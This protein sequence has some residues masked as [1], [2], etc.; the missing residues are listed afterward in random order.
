LVA[1]TVTSYAAAAARFVAEYTVDGQVGTLTAADVVRAV[2]DEC[3]RVS[4]GTAQYFVTALRSFLRFCRMQGLIDAEL[5]IAA[6]PVTGH[7]PSQLPK[8]ISSAEAAALLRS[9]DRRRAIGRRNYAVLLMLLRLGV[10]AGEVAALRLED[11]D[12]RAGQIV[13]RGKGGR[14]EPLPLPADVGEAIVAYLRRGRP[15]TIRREVF[16]TSR[17]PTRGLTRGA[18]SEIV[19]HACRRAGIPEVGAHRLR[20]M[21]ACAM[22]RADV[23]LAEIGQVLRHRDQA[24]TSTYARVDVGQLRRLARPWPVPGGERG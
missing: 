4:V 12:W 14:D 17:A 2:Q 23:P 6:L 22:V 21:A 16:V 10:R 20:H 9:C 3:G 15:A 18:V 1:S 5:S 24:T 13:I 8:Q 11:I 19:R 7:R